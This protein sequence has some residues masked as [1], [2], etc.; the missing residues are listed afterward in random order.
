MNELELFYSKIGSDAKPVIERF[1]SVETAKKFVNKFVAD[2]SF[3]LLKESLRESKPDD[4]FRAA[5]TLKGICLN[6]GFERLF[7]EASAVTELLRGGDIEKAKKIFPRLKREYLKT[8][9]LI[10][11]IQ[12]CSR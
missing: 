5:H 11:R 9:A 10:G 4:A 7:E 2:G 1:G 8:A 3:A 12:P 6:L